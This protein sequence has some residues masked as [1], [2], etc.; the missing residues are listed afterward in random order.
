VKATRRLV[1]K[2]F[3]VVG[4]A[5]RG[6]EKGLRD[7]GEMRR[8]VEKGLRDCGEMRRGVEKGLRDCG[9]MRRRIQ[10]D[11][12]LW[13]QL[14]GRDS[15]RRAGAGGSKRSCTSAALDCTLHHKSYFA[16][17]IVSRGLLAKPAHSRCPRR[18]KL[19]RV[20]VKTLV[21]WPVPSDSCCWSLEAR[22]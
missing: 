7:C 14:C 20:T 3:G 5:N 21:R 15:S 12:L 22:F 13:G 19:R 17:S 1:E 9:E 4:E 10:L 11:G 16:N 18:S 8:G 2:R 6:V